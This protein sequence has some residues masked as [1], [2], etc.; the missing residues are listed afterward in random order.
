MDAQRLAALLARSTTDAASDAALRRMVADSVAS[1]RV[2]LKDLASSELYQEE[3]P[4]LAGLAIAPG[5]EVL[6]A[7]IP[8]VGAGA[9]STRVVLG[10]LQRT[11]P[12][13]IPLEAPLIGQ[14]YDEAWDYGASALTASSSDTVNYVSALTASWADLPDG[15][16]R[17]AYRG[18]LLAAHSASGA[19]DLR[20]V[21]GVTA[22]GAT[23]PTAPATVPAELR[24][25]VA[26]VFSSIVV[27]GGGGI[28]LQLQYRP[29]VAG[30]ASARNPTL[31]AS[32]R[33]IG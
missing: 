1:G 19:V 29:G 13:A 30:T 8:G 2:V 23:D 31:W 18:D 22:G 21:A 9:G 10:R 27:S 11:P 25:A 28:S 24:I 14:V 6:V 7:E 15:T 12:A 4:R 33:R 32:A 16:Y 17:I 26:G 5:D 3:Y 20:V